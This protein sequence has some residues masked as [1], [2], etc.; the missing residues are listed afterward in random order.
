MNIELTPYDLNFKFHAGTSRGWLKT[1]RSY[2]CK[3]KDEGIESY[4]EC[5]L[6]PKLSPDDMTYIDEWLH[7]STALHS[8]YLAGT[9]LEISP[10]MNFAIEMALKAQ[11]EDSALL[12][13]KND[14]SAG[15]TGIPINGL[16]GWRFRENAQRYP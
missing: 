14:F 8:M 10:A 11:E 2:I 6:I 13:F 4:G 15:K 3:I 1:K 9:L 12:K 5:S 16:Y 7:D